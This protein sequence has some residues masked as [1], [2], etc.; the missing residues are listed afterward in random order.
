[1]SENYIHQDDL[2]LARAA[3]GGDETAWRRIYDE[4]T[5]THVQ[6]LSEG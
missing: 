4:N 2:D 3:T 5:K 6:T 1:M